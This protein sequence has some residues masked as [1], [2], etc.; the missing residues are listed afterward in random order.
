M[1]ILL[2]WVLW[3]MPRPH[4]DTTR[5][6]PTTIDNPANSQDKPMLPPTLFEDVEIV[7]S[8]IYGILVSALTPH[9]VRHWLLA[10]IRELGKALP[11]EQRREVDAAEARAIILAAAHLTDKSFTG[12]P[13]SFYGLLPH[14]DDG[15][16][17]PEK[18]VAPQ[19]NQPAT[20]RTGQGRRRRTRS[21][22]STRS[23]DRGGSVDR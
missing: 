15:A 14:A 16:S 22:S 3:P 17:Q 8:G 21:P 4:I 2:F 10:Q 7:A 18:G 20:R 13:L 9:I 23:G 5:L 1:A 6:T 12:V 19:L 11:I